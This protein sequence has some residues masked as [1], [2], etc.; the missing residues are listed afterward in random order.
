MAALAA[1]PSGLAHCPRPGLCPNTFAGFWNKGYHLPLLPLERR[2][3]DDWEAF[4]KHTHPFLQ[5]FVFKIVQQN[6]THATAQHPIKSQLH[7]NQCRTTS[8]NVKDVDSF[9]EFSASIFMSQFDLQ[10]RRKATEL[11][12]SA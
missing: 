3:T 5:L 1:S 6:Q 4:Q 9:Q 10:H 2:K 11:I 7:S 12:R 8:I